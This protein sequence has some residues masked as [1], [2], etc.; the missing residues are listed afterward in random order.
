[1]NKNAQLFFALVCLVGGGLFAVF[2]GRW[3]A[4]QGN[5]RPCESGLSASTLE[6]RYGVVVP[7]DVRICREASTKL[8]PVKRFEL[9]SAS[10]STLCLMTFELV[11]CPSLAKE[12]LRWTVAMGKRWDGG[13][14]KK[15]GEDHLTLDFTRKSAGPVHVSLFKSRYDEITADLE[16]RTSEGGGGKLKKGSHGDDD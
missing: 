3:A 16:V 1:V 12:G 6:E 14:G 11:G 13:E 7:D 2:M 15:S 8:E 10:P 9:V 4:Y 5:K